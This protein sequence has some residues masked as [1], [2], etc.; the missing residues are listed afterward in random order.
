MDTEIKVVIPSM[1]RAAKV[2]TK[3]FISG[4]KV[5]VPQKEYDEYVAHNPEI[6]V[7]QHPNQIKGL[8]AKRNWIYEHF[9]NV[10]MLDDDTFGIR[11]LYE[12]RADV[13]DPDIAYDIIQNLGNI[14]KLSGCYLFG[15]SKFANTLNYTGLKPFAMSG[16]INSVGIGLID[17]SK[18]KFADNIRC[19]NYVYISCLNAYYYRTCLIDSRFSI[20]QKGINNNTGGN[21]S[22]RT[23]D[24]DKEDIDELKRCFGSVLKFKQRTGSAKEWNISIK[25]PY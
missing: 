17:N 16:Y 20:I 21:S 2:T 23:P 3:N 7:V 8:G 19:N 9:K 1:G 14:A 22:L 6:E 15:F 25:L 13:C 12:T 10:F 4:C 5:C 24:S 11:R 18:L